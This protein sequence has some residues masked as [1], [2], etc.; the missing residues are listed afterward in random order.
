MNRLPVLGR[1][2]GQRLPGSIKATRTGITSY[3]IWKVISLSAEIPVPEEERK[4]LIDTLQLKNMELQDIAYTASHDLKSTLV[5]MGGFSGVL[6]EDFDYLLETL[7]KE[8]LSQELREKIEPL[9]KDEIPQSLG[10][11]TASVKKMASLL[12]GLLQV[13]KIGAVEIH[14]KIIDM[15]KAAREVLSAMAHQIKESHVTIKLEK[16][17]NCI[18]DIH[19]MDHVITNLISNAIKFRDLNKESRIII[20]GETEGDMTIYCV[21]DNGIGIKSDYKK[22]IFEVFHRLNPEDPI[23]SGEGIGL[24]IVSR[25]MDRLGGKVWLESEPG[26]G[27][28]FFIA[29]PKG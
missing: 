26:K 21:E 15:D 13:S 23:S 14:S 17:P 11:I 19:M 27:S 24:T 20:S 6:G 5:N 29:V 3:E 25:I 1:Y 10:F 7:F 18:G 9:I 4:K 8:N 12:D 16:L 22:K 28:K 2:W